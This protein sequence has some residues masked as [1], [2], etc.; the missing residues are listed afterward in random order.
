MRRKRNWQRMDS[1]E[2]YTIDETSVSKNIDSSSYQILSVTE[3]SITSEL[4]IFQKQS[5]Q[6]L[7]KDSI[8][9]FRQGGSNLTYSLKIVGFTDQ[10]QNRAASITGQKKYKG[11]GRSNR[12]PS[13]SSENESDDD[14]VLYLTAPT[15]NDIQTVTIETEDS[16]VVVPG[17]KIENDGA[18]MGTIPIVGKNDYSLKITGNIDDS[19]KNEGYLYGNYYKNY[20]LTLTITNISNI[21]S[22]PL[23]CTI[24]PEN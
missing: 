18:N 14:G 7:I 17:L 16:V 6:V 12:F 15:V 3:N 21:D 10:I 19:E 5:E 9:Y 4:G 11:K 23:L 24:E 1:G 2:V 20:P 22:S 8:P 13:Y